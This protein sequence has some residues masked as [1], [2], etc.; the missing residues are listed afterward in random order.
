MRFAGAVAEISA[1]CAVDVNI[2]KSRS[3]DAASGV[4]HFR[5][6]MRFADAVDL[7][8]DVPFAQGEIFAKNKTILN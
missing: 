5:L 8:I 2:N 6:A 1:I 7:S 4:Q 3:N